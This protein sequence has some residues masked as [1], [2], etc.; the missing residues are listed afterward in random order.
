MSQIRIHFIL[1]LIFTAGLNLLAFAQNTEI[2]THET[3]NRGIWIDDGLVNVGEK[4]AITVSLPGVRNKQDLPSYLT[5]HPGYLENPATKVE[6]LPLKWQL[7]ADGKK[8]VAAAEYRPAIAGN[9]Y[10]D[11][12][13]NNRECFAYFAA[14]KPSLTVTSFWVFMPQEYH[15]KGNLSD[16]Y[17]PEVRSG[18]LPFDYELG[19]V[20][21]K[22][23]QKNWQPRH[24]F[25]EAQ[26][27][28]AADIIPFFDGGYFHK[29]D[30]QFTDRFNK[31][32]QNIP[33]NANDVTEETLAFHDQ[34]LPD[35]TFHGLSTAQ[36]EAIINGARRYWKEWGFR[37]FTGI[38][39][40]CPSHTLIDACRRQGLPWVSGLF[41]DY[42][43]HDGTDRW[44]YSWVQEHY[45]M[46]SF[47]YIVSQNDYRRA[48]SADQQTTMIFPAQRN[49]PVWDHVMLHW[50]ALDAQNFRGWTNTTMANRMMDFA[51]AYHRNNE[52]NKLPFPYVVSYCMQFDS[53][54]QANRD[55]LK[56]LIARAA[57][58]ELIFAHKRHIQ[59]Y[60]RKHNIKQSPDLAC[61]MPDGELTK[62]APARVKN[63][64]N[65]D[66][67][68][69]WEGPDGK[70][71][72]V[73][74]DVP[75]LIF[76]QAP[77]LPIWWFDC[78]NK[79]A[80]KE[81]QNLP[82]E[83][84]SEVIVDTI[85][86]GNKIKL[87][88]TS[89]KAIERLPLCLWELSKRVNPTRNWILKNRAI[90]VGA[91]KKMGK[92][93][94]MWIIRPNISKGKNMIAFDL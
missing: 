47:P 23:F 13:D 2:S 93:A 89:P 50:A 74:N 62:G 26:E 75:A 10:A 58:G 53:Y 85:Q 25:R 91:P 92:N 72:F 68:A 46:P 12:F 20:G 17:L 80:L 6:K 84:L 34:M 67:E 86:E 76:K 82:Q 27:E 55:V 44:L 94:K 32:T 70:A 5:I 30:T 78:R 41:Q 45:G 21:E 90:A 61:G 7:S 87:L 49:L 11:I 24:L 3:S 59:R 37:D 29:L 77:Y 39:T 81:T 73:S 9:F 56:G 38:S 64:I 54:I 15:A 1:L 4:V 22:I 31:I 33:A 8:W 48:G 51:D 28:T 69:W 35:P 14:W 88:V 36:C 57:K 40:Y 19:L 71:A 42:S 66:Y 63:G 43:F 16:L 18:H 83:D 52:I 65:I 60:F 79:A